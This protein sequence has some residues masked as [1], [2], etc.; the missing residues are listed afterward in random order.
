MASNFYFAYGSNM[1]PQRMRD[2]K[3]QFVGVWGARAQDLALR[4]N[5]VSAGHTGSA[6]ANLVYARGTR[7]EGVLYELQDAEEIRK[8]DPFENAPIN[9]SRE[10][11][12]VTRGDGAAIAA[13]TYFANP[14][15]IVPGLN[16]T[17]DYL[18]HLLLGEPYLSPD[19][20]VR[21]RSQPTAD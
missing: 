16:P 8:L 18:N 5:K 4:F 3:L 21:L 6:H 15:V 14:A 7:A 1:N 2:R 17:R 19:Y 10:P 13:W 12:V 11:L 9:Y 20:V